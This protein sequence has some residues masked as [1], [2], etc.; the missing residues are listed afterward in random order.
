MKC[1]MIRL[2]YA[3]AFHSGLDDYLFSRQKPYN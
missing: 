2:E 3:Q 1:G